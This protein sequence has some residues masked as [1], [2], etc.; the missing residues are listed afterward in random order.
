M[1]TRHQKISRA[2]V[3]ARVEHRGNHIRCPVHHG[4]DFNCSVW[5]VD[6]DAHFECKSR[7]CD[8]RKIRAVFES[9]TFAPLPLS[10]HQEIAS[11]DDVKRTEIAQ[12]VWSA[13][14]PAASTVVETYLRAR[15]ITMAVPPSLRFHPR[16]RHPSDI[17]LPGMV[18][19]ITHANTGVKV[20]AVH[21]TFLRADGRAK[22]DIEPTK[23]ML[24]P[25][26]GGAVRLAPVCGDC[27][28]VCEGIETGLSLLQAVGPPVWA[29]L[30]T[31]G[32]RALT[33]PP[34]IRRV[35]IAAD[36]DEPGEAAAQAAAAR[37]MREGRMCGSHG[38]HGRAW[39]ST[40]FERHCMMAV[41]GTGPV[42]EAIK[43]AAKLELGRVADT[44]ER[45]EVHWLWLWRIAR[46]KI[47][48]VDGDP[49]LG[50]TLVALLFD[51]VRLDR[52][53]F[54][55]WCSLRAWLSDFHKR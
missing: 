37:F 34:E 39:I 23:A 35:I 9:G 40:I 22:A 27:L 50:K 32:L 12:R 16:L 48:V 6:G 42:E 25:S 2:S 15:G 45:K 26:R 41:N 53:A 47:T 13:S 8:W 5:E 46:G 49:G 55:G 36:A 52:N 18:A 20:Q 31:S 51:G 24:G 29:A 43:N 3:L 19:C 1:V 14:R 44:I 30:S 54:S 21:R 4:K 38:L 10:T 17:Y 33:L 28:I 11:L 7:H